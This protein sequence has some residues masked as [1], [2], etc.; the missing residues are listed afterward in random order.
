MVKKK[1]REQRC[2]QLLFRYH[3]SNKLA[4][5]SVEHIPKM[6]NRQETDKGNEDA[7]GEVIGEG[8][9]C[10]SSPPS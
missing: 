5:E 7:G 6:Q 3:S 1:H 9:F 4:K 2:K 10:F 8:L